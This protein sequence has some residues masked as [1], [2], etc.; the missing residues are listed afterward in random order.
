MRYTCTDV[1]IRDVLIALILIN[2]KLRKWLVFLFKYK[3][4]LPVDN[5]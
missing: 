2:I 1:P 3:Y 4:G 5:D